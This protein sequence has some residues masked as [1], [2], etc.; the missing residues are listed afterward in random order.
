LILKLPE[1]YATEFCEDMDE[2]S[3][4]ALCDLF[5]NCQRDAIDASAKAAERWG[6][7]DAADDIRRLVRR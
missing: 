6:N 1:E 7:D 2:A 3:H 4:A 5:A